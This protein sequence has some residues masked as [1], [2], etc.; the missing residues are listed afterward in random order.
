MEE[1]VE[2]IKNK[3]V[4][5][6]SLTVLLIIIIGSVLTVVI[7]SFLYQKNQEAVLAKNLN[8]LYQDIVVRKEEE[9]RH[10][11]ND[12]KRAMH[13]DGFT[14]DTPAV[15][16]HFADEL[17]G[18]AVIVIFDKDKN[19]IFSNDKDSVLE[20]DMGYCIVKYG[21]GWYKAGKKS[22][23]YYCNSEA[24]Y[25]KGKPK[26]YIVSAK[27]LADMNILLEFKEIYGSEATVFKKDIRIATTIRHDG[28][29]IT[30]S[31]MRNKLV[32]QLL[33][34]KQ[35]I[36]T[37]TRVGGRSY[38]GIYR[39][40]GNKGEYPLLIL[41]VGQDSNGFYTFLGI[42]ILAIC[43]IGFTLLAFSIWGSNRWI[44]RGVIRFLEKMNNGLNDVA[45]EKITIAEFERG[46]ARY[47]EFEPIY[48]AIF[49]LVTKLNTSYRSLE[50]VAYFDD[51]TGLPN[52]AKLRA[53]VLEKENG[54]LYYLLYLDLDNIRYVNDVSGHETGDQV[55]IHA[56]RTLSDIIRLSGNAMLYGAGGDEFIVFMQE[57]N[58][59]HVRHTADQIVHCFQKPIF[60]NLLE[61]DI[62][63][64]IGISK[65]YGG[66]AIDQ[67]LHEAEIAMYVIKKSTKNGYIFFDGDMAECIRKRKEVED[68]LKLAIPRNEIYLVLQ[69]K[70]SVHKTD[71][72]YFEALLRWNSKKY[73][74][75]KPI[76]FIPIAE[77][78][79]AI[80]HLGNWVIEE[81]CR[82]ICA[83]REQFHKKICISVNISALQLNRDGFTSNILDTIHKFGLDPCN[84][85]LE[86]TE[87]LLID[88]MESAIDKLRRL[89]NEGIKIAIDD[90]G[91]GYSSLSYLSKLPIDILK[92]DKYFVDMVGTTE[93]V[94]L[95]EIINLGQGMG[96]KIVAEGVECEMQYSYIVNSGCDFIQGYYHSK[97]LSFEQ[98]AAYIKK[99]FFSRIDLS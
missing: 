58:P 76:D 81:S 42:V 90:F 16:N 26:Y 20:N 96:L 97:P 98:S 73:G 51:L 31:K 50:K 61:W 39:S 21:D 10:I 56:A 45:D 70:L 23:L 35:K 60:I 11:I 74:E 79:D 80:I 94:I 5:I 83:L 25:E 59:E 82:M 49:R 33:V 57:D 85:E 77:T 1:K 87:T 99:E 38:L 66:K 4:Q 22:M 64:S 47:C 44:D 3:I 27:S 36:V 28:K 75:V 95:R 34:A 48:E 69:P 6:I 72:V 2:S 12:V 24:V 43:A 32:G 89:R 9:N 37:H 65:A 68:E 55:I 54:R 46:T 93:D 40:Y 78:S 13:I 91:K 14:E 7:S 29:F 18:K 63:V 53:D 52:R 41:F 92:I 30:G 62:T 8:K 71:T 67:M 86:V 17:P 15:G 19:M 84:L 88:S